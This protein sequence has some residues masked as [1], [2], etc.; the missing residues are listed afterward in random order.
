MSG[1]P[2][3]IIG[4]VVAVIAL[5]IFVFLGSRLGGGAAGTGG[6]TITTKG[7]LVAAR[8]I[9]V[10]VPLTSADVKVIQ[11]DVNALPPQAFDKV[12]QVKGL[13]PVVAIYQGQSVTSN[14]L[15]S[16]SDQVV[17][18]QA[19]FL[20]I[21]SG[22]VALTLPTSEQQGVAG[23]IQAGDYIAISAIVNPGGKFSNTRTVYTNVHVLR[24][25]TAADAPSVQPAVRPAPGAVPTPAPKPPTASSITV[26]V[27]QCQAEFL[28][29]FIA[30]ATLRYTLESYRNY[31]PKDI[32]VDA[33]CP[34]VDSAHGVTFNDVTRA[35]PTLGG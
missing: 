26:V 5:G 3:T 22:F 18:A 19:A 11:V 8:D 9:A 20:P 23:N 28:E 21:P 17:G 25:G 24:I 34:G 15:V 14:L 29:W 1:R 30:N 33:G 35:W 32:A 13:I 27:T 10:R 4:A 2:F 6:G 12:D 7:L 31:S 16:S